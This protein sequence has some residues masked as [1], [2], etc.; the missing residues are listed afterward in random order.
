MEKIRKIFEIL[1]GK[2]NKNEMQ[3]EIEEKKRCENCE[4]LSKIIEELKKQID[5]NNQEFEVKI[6]ES[7]TKI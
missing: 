6:N 7:I 4:R 1:T 3:H 5:R 2:N